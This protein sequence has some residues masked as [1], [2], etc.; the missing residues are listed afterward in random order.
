MERRAVDVAER[1]SGDGLTI[2]ASLRTWADR[3]PDRTAFTFIPDGGD[4][5]AL[6]YAGLDRRASAVAA[7]LTE[8]EAF[9]QPVL[10]LYPSGLEYVAALFGCLYAGAI[11]VPVGPPDPLRLDRSLPRLLAIIRDARPH[12]VLTTDTIGALLGTLSPSVPEVA[13]LRILTT[14][15][16]SAGS[17][18]S[19]PPVWP[20]PESVALLQYTSGSTATPRGVVLTYR[21]LTSNCQLIGVLLGHSGRSRG[22][23]WVPPYHDMGLIGGIIQPV[24]AGFPVTLMDPVHFIREPLRWL[25]EISRTRATTSG[26]P[27]FAYELCVRKTTADQRAQLD[28]S[29]WRVAINGSEPVRAGAM[30]KFARAFEPTGF[31]REAFRPCYGLAEATLMVTGGQAW[32]P[33]AVL[34]FDSSSSRY[35]RP[36]SAP[37]ATKPGSRR[38]VSCGFA[39]DAR[40]VVIAN[41]ETGDECLPG[42][43]GEIWVVGPAVARGYWNRPA[44]S[45]RTF[46]ARLTG[47]SEGPFLR[48]GDL[49]F[50]LDRQLYITGRLKE[51]I[52]VRGRNHYPQDIEWSAERSSPVLRPGRAAAFTDPADDQD[53]LVIV[54]EI[55]RQAGDVDVGEVATAIRAAVAADYQIEVHTVVLLPPGEIPKTSSGKIQRVLCAAMFANGQLAELGRSEMRVLSEDSQPRLDR[56]QLLPLPYSQ[57]RCQL[58]EYLSQLMAQ[59][60]GLDVAEVAGTPLSGLGL[61]SLAVIRIQD[62][63]QTDLDIRV[64]ASD[65]ARVSGVVEL[66]IWLEEQITRPSP[67]SSGAPGPG[68][69]GADESGAEP[70]RQYRWVSGARVSSEDTSDPGPVAD[71]VH[72]G[73]PGHQPRKAS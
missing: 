41:P 31:R 70:V 18:S 59:A 64:T 62:A 45:G 11:A 1:A 2:V 12:A 14:S 9:R 22:V 19:S 40:S 68:E 71:G 49:G 53:R 66:A 50:L 28:L 36:V 23:S 72:G 65:M 29:S 51:L 21:N 38:L 57:R 42:E 13:R 60:G 24:Y 58:V 47:S 6:S 56:A 63:I 54:H 27:S 17:P 32:S 33:R 8:L 44:E 20:E 37:S 43:V 46:Q 15:Q 35:G 5:Q 52:I 69:S 3:Q 10:L 61:D 67:A 39:A 30:E 26:G 55:V 4:E 34:S 7:L 73:R 48:T 16:V 25:Q